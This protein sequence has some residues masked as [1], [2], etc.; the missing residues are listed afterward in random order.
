MC[1][2]IWKDSLLNFEEDNTPVITC[3]YIEKNMFVDPNFT[4]EVMNKKST[5]TGV[6]KN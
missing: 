3:E 1:F 6:M 2:H 4:V 5:T